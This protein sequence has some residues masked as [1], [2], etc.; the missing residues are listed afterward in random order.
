MPDPTMKI[1]RCAHADFLQILDDLEDFWGTDR[2]RAV[3]HPM[4]VHEFGDT[5]WVVREDGRVIAYLFGFW[6]QTEPVGYVH[7]VGVR[8]SHQRRG[9]GRRLYGRFEERARAHG[10]TALKAITS[11]INAESIA[12]HRSLGFSLEGEPGEHGVPV[13][14]DYFGPG[15]ARIVFH[16]PIGDPSVITDAEAHE[17]E[18]RLRSLGYL[19]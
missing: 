16:K 18:E 19:E 3:H 17:I 7:L 14:P 11:P 9:I 15:Q 2:A 6:S 8:R 12:F 5:A 4:F 13:V 1:E 10:C